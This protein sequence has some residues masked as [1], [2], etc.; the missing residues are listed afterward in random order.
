M[1]LLELSQTIRAIRKK[2][3]VTVEYLAKKSGFSKGFISQVEN[4]R[5]T[6]SLKVLQRIADALGVDMG[7]LFQGDDPAPA[8]SYCHLD[9]GDELV[10]DDN[11]RYGM[12]Y[13]SLAY[14][15]IGRQMNPFIV[16]YR[17]GEEVRP[18][19][20]HD[21]EEFFVLLEGEVICCAPDEAHSRKMCAGDTVYFRANLPH[22]V[23]LAG[24]CT[25][26]KA[27]IVYAPNA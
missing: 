27:L 1:N 7:G 2:Q 20:M 16:E 8:C 9:E 11:Q 14:R 10:R 25:Y 15:Q 26:A 12:R 24:D 13:L 21:T 22:R 18:F 6:P 19:L 4:F 5:T 3:G 23:V 17:P